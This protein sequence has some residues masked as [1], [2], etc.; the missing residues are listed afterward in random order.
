MRVSCVD[1]GVRVLIENRT[2]EIS[3]NISA[4]S[5]N[6]RII[7]SMNRVASEIDVDIVVKWS[8]AG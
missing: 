2:R 8:S 6:Q 5:R 7:L 3:V 1:G 4:F